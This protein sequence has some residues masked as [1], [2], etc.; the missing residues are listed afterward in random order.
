M[1]R[2]RYDW[3]KLSSDLVR[4]IF[5]GLATKDYH[6]A[7]TVCSNWYSISTTC[8]RPL[9][10]W[11]I[12]LNKNSILLYDPKEDKIQETEH[13]GIDFSIVSVMASCSNWLL[14]V[15]TRLNFYLLNV[16]TRETIVLPSMESS[17][18]GARFERK[19][20]WEHFIERTDIIS[21]KKAAVL[22]INERTRDYVVAW[23]YKRH[24]LFSYKNGDDSWLKLEGTDCIDLAYKGD[25]LYVLA[26]DVRKLC[27]KIFDLSLKEVEQGNPYCNLDTRAVLKHGEPMWKSSV[28][29]TNSGEVL[30]IVSLR[31]L[32]QKCLL[33]VYKM[34]LESGNWERVDSLGG[35][36]LIFG[37]GVTIRAPV[38]EIDGGGIKSDSIGFLGCDLW[39]A[40]A[41]F[42]SDNVPVKCG[43]FDLATSTITWPEVP[44]GVSYFKSFW[45]V[46]GYA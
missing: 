46:P 41:Y 3:S 8:K 15:D 34:N 36:M 31:G 4:T 19:D 29:I 28:A 1:S 35:E 44:V 40:P 6:R 2:N 21:S 11:R 12:L 22:W 30:I 43:V 24:F 38:K 18:L 39:P 7:R 9:Y 13:P 25:K 5:E 42:H 33:Y 26:S 20:E 14:I 27:I 32:G 45:F 10:P 23:S 16:F 37:H 17:L